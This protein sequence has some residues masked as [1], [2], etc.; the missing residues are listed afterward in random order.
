[1]QSQDQKPKILDQ[2]RDTMHLHHYSIH[3][4][5]TYLDRIKRF[6]AFHRMKSR[7]DLSGGESKI[8]VFLARLAV[9]EQVASAAQNQAM[10][11]Q[12]FLYKRVLQQPLNE[13][14]NAVRS[15][16]KIHVPVVL[17][18]EE[19]EKVIHDQDIAQGHEC[20]LIRLVRAFFGAV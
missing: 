3:T 2:V 15:E 20:G 5:R 7:D 8:E 17:T 11:A 13:V 9:D 16:K 19:V 4:E 10:N 6:L 12:V 18:R 1:M 14:I